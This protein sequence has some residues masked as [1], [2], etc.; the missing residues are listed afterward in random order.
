M[1]FFQRDPKKE[2][3]G[4]LMK[5]R[6]AFTIVTFLSAVTAFTY[7]Q[8]PAAADKWE[9]DIKKFEAADRLHPPPAGAVVFVGSSS[10]RFWKLADSFPGMEALNRGFGGSQ[11]ADSA[12]YADRIVTP[13]RPRAVVVYAGD[14]DLADGKTPE[15]V[16]DAYRDFVAKV[17]AKLPTV[18]I[19]Y[20]GIK[21]CE[22]RW[23]LIA[24]VKAANQLIVEAQRG[25]S[26][27][28][29]VNTLGPMLGADGRP[30]PELF[31]ADKLH[32]NDDGYQVWA[33]LLKPL[34][35]P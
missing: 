35:K 33:E 34:L 6:A 18:P 25:D 17:R 11:L 26:T 5:R 8:A 32:L 2:D 10:I 23:K 27:Q 16:R 7:G 12:R 20:I 29:F 15:Q 1:R 9:A 14:N 28:H 3:A 4:T 30:R 22:S 21:P 31:R 13:Y 24:K 19:I